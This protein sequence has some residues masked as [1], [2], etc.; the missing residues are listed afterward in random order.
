MWLRF[1]MKNKNAMG[2]YYKNIRDVL[3]PGFEGQETYAEYS[4]LVDKIL[5]KNLLMNR[6]ESNRRKD[7]VMG[8][9]KVICFAN[10]K[11]GS[12]KSTTCANVGYG[13]TQL[14]KKVLLIDGD[15]QLNLSLS[16][17]D[18]DKVLAFA[19]SDKNLYEGIRKQADLTDYIVK[20]DF[21]NLT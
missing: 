11:G 3:R 4:Q 19:Q 17:F 2:W 8:K 10:N 7:L 12:G 15:M 14:G 13:L 18:E 6:G 20:S 21:E 1:R 9:T 5:G 16:L